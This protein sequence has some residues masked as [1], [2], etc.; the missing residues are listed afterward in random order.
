MNIR[1]SFRIALMIAFVVLAGA[2]TSVF[3]QNWTSLSPEGSMC[4]FKL[5]G[6]VKKETS[7]DEKVS[8][9]KFSTEYEG[10]AFLFSYTV[11]ASDLSNYEGLAVTSLESFNESLGGNIVSQ[12]EW[13]V[14]KHDGKKATIQLASLN[15]SCQYRVVLAGQMQYQAVVVAPIDSY[16]AKTAGKFFKSIK[17]KQ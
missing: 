7:K 9:Y 8:T 5:P 11:H 3:A 17:I 15:A 13:K 16:D 4:K 12:E 2:S 6:E 14:K 10:C 1:P